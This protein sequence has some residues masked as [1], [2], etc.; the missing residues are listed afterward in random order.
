M[1]RDLKIL[2]LSALL[3]DIGKFAQRAKRPFSKEMEG[4]YLTNFKGKPGHWHT[5]YTDYFIEKDLLLPID[6]ENDRSR[7]ARMSSAHH[8]PDENSLSEMSIMIADCLSAGTDR[9][10]EE[11]ETK[12]GFRE[13]RLVS[14]F[15]EIELV[16]HE[17]SPPGNSYYDLVPLESGSDT[18]FPR[19]GKPKGAPEEYE[20]LFDQF[21]HELENLRADVDFGFYLEGL[22]SLSE[23]F[24]WCIPSSSYKTLSDISLFDHSFSTAG[25]AQ[26]LYV[27]HVQTGGIPRK[28]D[29]NKKFILLGGDL[30]GI[31]DYIF[32]ISKNSGR[33]VS[34][35]FRARSFFLQ[36]LTRSV[37]LEIQ[38][39]VGLFSVCRLVDSGGKFIIL[40]PSTPSV[41][42]Q[43]EKIDEEMQS[44][45]R[46]R[47]K[48]LL[49]MNISF[50]VKLS[51]QDFYLDS[52][53]TRI[54]EVNEALQISK[55][56]KLRKTFSKDG[57][58]IEG[59]YDENEGGNCSLCGINAADKI[60]AEKYM[61]KEGIEIPVCRDCCDQIVYIGTRLPRT[62]Y[63]VYGSKENKE[64]RI[65]LFGDISLIL[66]DKKPKELKYIRHVETLT[67]TGMFSRTRIARH[68]PRITGEEL[69]D[70]RWFNLFSQ[71]EDSDYI[72]E[73]KPKT[74]NM[75]AQ[76]S[77]KKGNGGDLVG[78]PLLG[79]FK[80]DVDNLGMIFSMGLGDK[81]S[82]ARLTSA[83]RMLNV[84]FSE[85][86][87]ELAKKEFPDIY[88]VFAGG[89]DLFM[90]GPWNQAIQ[91]AIE[92]RKKLSLY[93]ADNPDITL[94]GGILIAKPRLPMRKAVE[95][96]ESH[97]ET[98]KQFSKENRRKDS[99]CLLGEAFSWQV[100]E[101][102]I[103]LGAKFDK[104]VEEKERTAFSMAFLYRLLEY[105]KMYRKFTFENKIK[106]KIKFG[107]YL[108]LAHYDIARNILDKKN[109]NQE[110]LDMLYDIFV[111]GVS[112][113]PVLESLNVPLFY[114][115]NSNRKD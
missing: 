115:I 63:L 42:N 104:A 23:K 35:I 103:K 101:E 37:M 66:S 28:N 7:I 78:R 47:F 50:A 86:I 38:N 9:I 69:K 45:F 114:A 56:H 4:E 12:T 1:E 57:P 100:V 52:F 72:E 65:H 87:V 54:D 110:E 46:G 14:V 3:H 60:A 21:F 8:R 36:A 109:R 108:S 15:D 41:E 10:K 106:N 70:E 102:L 105:H 79:F 24:T 62:G 5:V 20:G 91:F 73:D 80:A 51:Q 22:I 97:L 89:D 25:I 64:G 34:K 59:D 18:I 94:S 6:L 95:L 44:W 85:Y 112:E 39:R 84:F 82:V 90:I 92:L 53:Q 2:V 27:Y 16:N 61:E 83:S 55:L 88:V 77:K 98:A 19:Q 58:I 31:Q 26:S 99:L 67:D 113:R 107:R 43:L 40:L 76:K 71:E 33:G 68:L 81:L 11:N 74:F 32:G 93:C 30:S 75:I 49:T 111:V 13:S 48:G 96:T 29:D 17:F